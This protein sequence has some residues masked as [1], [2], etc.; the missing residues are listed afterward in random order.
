M[1]RTPMAER[2]PLQDGLPAACAPTN[3]QE[4][5]HRAITARPSTAGTSDPQRSG[6]TPLRREHQPSTSLRPPWCGSALRAFARF[7]GPS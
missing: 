6:V 2:A 5:R 1:P 7:P 3:V 4:E